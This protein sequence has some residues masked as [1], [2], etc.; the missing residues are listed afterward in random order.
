[1]PPMLRSMPSSGTDPLVIDTDAIKEEAVVRSKLAADARPL[2][3][4]NVPIEPE[5]W[6]EDNT[7]ADFPYRAAV[8]CSGVGES[9]VPSVTFAPTEALSGVFAPVAASYDGGVYIYAAEKLE[10]TLNILGIL[11]IPVG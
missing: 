1:M 8:S 7:Y 6:Q 11:C 4:E 2:A 9:F 5:S 3:F 10:A